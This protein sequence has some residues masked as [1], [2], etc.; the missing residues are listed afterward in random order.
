MKK[1][2]VRGCMG[3]GLC[4]VLAMSVSA[5]PWPINT[6]FESPNYSIGDLNGQQGWSTV[7]DVAVTADS[8]AV[9]SGS[10]GVRLTSSSQA[11]YEADSAASSVV[12]I[13]GYCK[14]EPVNFYPELPA[15]TSVT[16]F[17]FFHQTQGI[18]C[19]DGDGVGSGT[20]VSSGMVPTDWTRLSVRQDYTAHNW[21][22][23]VNGSRVLSGLGNAYHN[24]SFDRFEAQAGETGPMYLDAFYSAAQQPFAGFSEDQQVA[25][26][27]DGQSGVFIYNY[28]T[29]ALSGWI[30]GTPGG[31]YTADYTLDPDQWYGVFLYDYTAAIYQQAFYMLKDEF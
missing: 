12:W 9:Y 22:L 6:D 30:E 18:V 5:A 1:W 19:L 11:I 21:D 23:Y 14:A 24:S 7:N 31:T 27:S 8:E 13:Q 17:L 4:L 15:P 2:Y 26:S 29:Y 20:W 28:A 10:Q 3:F 25:M 16:C